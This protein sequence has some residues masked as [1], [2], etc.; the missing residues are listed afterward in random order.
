[1]SIE[2]LETER[3]V[4][5]P[6]IPEDAEFILRLL[7]E[8]SFVQHI[9]DKGVR[10]LEQSVGY[11]LDGPM[12]SYSLHGHGLLRVE[13]RDTGR[14][15]GM[16][17]LLRRNP[18]QDPDLGYAFMPEAWGKGYALE[19]AL[20]VLE[21]SV[22]GL[23]FSKILALVAPDNARSIQLLLKLGF[24]LSESAPTHPEAEPVS[25][26]EWCPKDLRQ[27]FLAVH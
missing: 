4:L 8:P 5:R 1:M 16:C 6:F 15:I 10:T 19:A 12:Q 2:I 25:I 11:L 13:I 23:G 17:G 27:S 24:R 26:Y 20:A 18:V 9:G 3:L 21:S 22:S 7:N 14:P